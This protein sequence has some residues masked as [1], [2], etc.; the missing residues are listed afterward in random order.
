MTLSRRAKP[1]KMGVRVNA[2]I[3]SQSHQKWVRGFRCIGEGI[4]G[5]VCS[6]SIEFAHCRVGTDGAMSEKPSDCWGN[7]MCA[8][9][10][11]LQHRIGES[12]LQALFKLD[13]KS[14]ALGY[15]RLSPHRLKWQDHSANPLRI[16]A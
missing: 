10:H 6:G 9:L 13:L 16:A 12:V 4:A 8:G 15:W 2:W 1:P 5:H 3:R 11:A 7:P 14:S